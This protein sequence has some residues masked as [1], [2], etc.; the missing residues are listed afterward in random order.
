MADK[1]I[2]GGRDTFTLTIPIDTNA[3]QHRKPLSVHIPPHVIMN[4]AEV[5]HLDALNVTGFKI[6]S[7]NTG[8]NMYTATLYPGKPDES[9]ERIATHERHEDIL[10]VQTSQLSH[11]MAHHKI[12]NGVSESK[13][14]TTVP[15]ADQIHS[16]ELTKQ[17]LPRAD[18]L[19]LKRFI[20]S[21]DTPKS[22]SAGIKKV[23]D[24][25][26]LLVCEKSNSGEDSYLYP[27]IKRG[28]ELDGEFYGIKPTTVGND[29]GFLIT[30]SQY[31]NLKDQHKDFTEIKS[32]YVNGI[33]LFV[34]QP[35]ADTEHASVEVDHDK[36]GVP[37]A[38]SLV[39]AA[40]HATLNEKAAIKPVVPLEVTFTRL[41]ISTTTGYDVS[42]AK[43]AV[44]EPF[45]ESHGAFFA[46][47]KK[48]KPGEMAINAQP[49]ED[50][51][52]EEGNYD[53]DEE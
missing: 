19:M 22:L 51:S 8:S 53:I 36:K 49:L 42:H 46:F 14:Y 6:K 33:T 23:P 7:N 11:F 15:T 29:T 39:K 25:T 52:D 24:A 37:K 16:L 1:V 28:T 30:K 41:P 4:A 12:T 35:H 47:G 9:S 3:I 34:N 2:D 31:Q 38:S 20:T 17:K 5:R 48:M 18:H 21:D 27:I 45:R 10:P 13:Q 43:K 26:K 50:F 32:P 40:V 44:A